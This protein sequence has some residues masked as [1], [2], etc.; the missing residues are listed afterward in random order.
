MAPMSRTSSRFEHTAIRASAGAG[1]THR[2]TSRFIGLLA[3]N[4]LP[5]RVLATTFTRKAAGEILERILQRLA[6]AAID[7]ERCTALGNDIG[8][9]S[10]SP[11][12][13]C[14]LVGKLA[15]AP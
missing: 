9:S 3:A 12:R 7:P 14:E 13:A 6:A 15:R 5:D 8:D 11:A 4:E 10:I 2:L 1:K